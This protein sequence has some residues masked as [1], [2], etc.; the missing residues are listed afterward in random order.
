[1]DREKKNLRIALDFAVAAIVILA[2]QL[3]KLICVYKLKGRPTV[4]IIENVIH[5]TYVENSGA[6]FGMLKD[7]RWIFMALTTVFVAALIYL[8]IRYNPKLSYFLNVSL[9]FIIGGGIRR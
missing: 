2:D 3:T 8:L 9:A 5:F 6:A 4:P 1:M 7:A